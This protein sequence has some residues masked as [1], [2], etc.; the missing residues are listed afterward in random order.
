LLR[1]NSIALLK[2]QHLKRKLQHHRHSAKQTSSNPH[3][4]HNHISRNQ[5]Y[6]G[7]H[8]LSSTLNACSL[9]L[10]YTYKSPKFSDPNEQRSCI[11]ENYP[12]A[13]LPF[14]NLST[15]IPRNRS[16]STFPKHQYFAFCMQDRMKKRPPQLHA[17]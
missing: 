9:F 3:P 5:N 10:I 16:K 11:N 17:K 13:L 1:L 15:K 8:F 12:F 6:Q 2:N 14:S 7:N 4:P